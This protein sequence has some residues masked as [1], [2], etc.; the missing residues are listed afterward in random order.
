[1]DEPSTMNKKNLPRIIIFFFLLTGCLLALWYLYPKSQPINSIAPQPTEVAFAE[2][3]IFADDHYQIA[4][5]F[6]TEGRHDE[7]LAELTSIEKKYTNPSDQ[8][9]L[10]NM[11]AEQMFE[12]GD[13]I[14]GAKRL[15]NVYTNASLA[16]TT[17]AHAM[18][19]MLLRYRKLDDAKLFEY[20]LPYNE[21][22]LYY[23]QD[24]IEQNIPKLIFT[25][26][27]FAIID[28][29]F[30]LEKLLE[31]Q[32]KLRPTGDEPELNGLND[33]VSETMREFDKRARED[34]AFLS[35][36][37][38]MEYL[39]PLTHIAMGRLY[40]IIHVGGVTLNGVSAKE[41]AEKEYVDAILFA[42]QIGR[43]DIE[44][45]AILNYANHFA[46]GENSVR[47]KEIIHTLETQKTQKL[48]SDTLRSPKAQKLFR[49]LS[50]L[51][52][53]DPSVTYFK[54]FGW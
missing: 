30:V 41:A 9:I 2:S 54:Q 12:S 17:R 45:L 36:A 44:Q 46:L 31:L 18:L 42:R 11:I 48:T 32:G 6:F 1:M 37:P 34:I 26:H 40:T 24:T 10:S 25:L 47:A 43:A 33:A 28:A 50:A 22:L 13:R 51:V 3:A 49:G 53:A 5:K 29:G 16:S 21:W 15:A 7:A 52:K 23:S 20:F 19:M 14:G 38:E 39:V 27:P 4:K 8:A 35:Q